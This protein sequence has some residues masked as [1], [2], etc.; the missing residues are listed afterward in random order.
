MVDR[1][2]VSEGCL[3]YRQLVVLVIYGAGKN[4]QWRERWWRFDEIDS[5]LEQGTIPNVV[6]PI[7]EI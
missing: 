5:G 3:G 7:K 4:H 1:D 2:A 6:E